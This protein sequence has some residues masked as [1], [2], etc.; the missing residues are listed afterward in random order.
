[1]SFLFSI[2]NRIM[3][4]LILPKH[5]VDGLRQNLTSAYKVGGWVKANAY[6]R[7]NVNAD[8]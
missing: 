3:D 4:H 1:M 5:W 2:K 6:V 8:L 7:K